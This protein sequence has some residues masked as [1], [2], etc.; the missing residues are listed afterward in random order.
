TAAGMPTSLATVSNGMLS[1]SPPANWNG[2]TEITVTATDGEY[3]ANSTILIH[4]L[5]VNDPVSV[6]KKPGPL[7]IPQGNSVSINL[8]QYFSDP[9]SVL[10]YTANSVVL[11][12]TING[13]ILTVSAPKSYSGPASFTVTAT[14]GQTK[15]TLAFKV[16]VEAEAAGS[17]IPA[18]GGSGSMI[19]V[20]AAGVLMAVAV[21]AIAWLLLQQRRATSERTTVA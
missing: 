6:M 10:T 15:E 11:D 20:M 21:G 9:D 19:G 2:D 16:Q 8:S 12:I 14:D 3:T 4:I 5:P 18:S 1:I 7:A 17:E 13:D